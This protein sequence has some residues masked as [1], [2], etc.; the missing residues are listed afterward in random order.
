LPAFT[1]TATSAGTDGSSDTATLTPPVTEVNDPL[2]LEMA[3]P[4]SFTEGSATEGATVTTVTSATDPDGGAIT[5]SIDDTTNYAIDSNTGAVTLTAAGAARVNA[6]TG[7]NLPAFTVTATSAGTD[8]SSDTATLTPPVTEVNDAPVAIAAT[9]SVAEDATIKGEVKASDVDLPAD[10]SL[11]FTT[12]ST[13]EGLTLNSDG[14]YTFDAASY[15][16]LEAG[17]KLELIVPVTVTDDQG[18]TAETTLTITV[19]GTNDAPT[20][21]TVTST[22]S[23]NDPAYTVNLLT[24]S[25]AEDIDGESVTYVAGS[26]VMTSTTDAGGVIIDNSTGVAN[27]NPAHYSYLDDG[28]SVE[29]TYS[30]NV[31]DGI[32]VVANTATI[33]IT[34]NNDAPI[35]ESITLEATEDRSLVAQ[36]D[37]AVLASDIDD[38]PLS[39]VAGSFVTTEGGR[40][41]V[42]SDGSFTYEPASNFYGIDSVTYSVTDGDINTQATIT[43]NVAGVA[44]QVVV[45]DPEAVMQAS[46]ESASSEF[47]SSGFEPEGDDEGTDEPKTITFEADPIARAFDS[48]LGW[49]SSLM[50]QRDIPLQ[51]FEAG[52]GFTSFAFQIP[53]DTFGHTDSGIEIDVSALMADGS[54]IP[55][56]LVFD[57]EQGV[58]RGIPPAGFEGVLTVRVIARDELGAQVETM[59]SIEVELGQWLLAGVD[60]KPR[61]DQ[62]LQNQSQFAWRSQR[63]SLLAAVQELRD[64]NDG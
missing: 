62:V 16:S 48:E 54:E 32:A 22:T 6:D 1:V 41:T 25:A 46:A 39:V 18:A 34:G 56:W 5:Y 10:T 52:D 49:Q 44:E 8:G 42:A 21:S 3:T 31:T 28:E 14:S 37:L 2:T 15:D 53:T 60:G 9:A 13:V 23:E 26:T 38:E 59:V 30:F 50:V 27:V 40:F 11:I 36:L 7:A 51:K 17:E 24:A 33:R 4:T 61:V 19:T 55:A 47:T 45:A 12:T 29:V 20:V 58:F 64:E 63:D 35:V 43:F 57:A